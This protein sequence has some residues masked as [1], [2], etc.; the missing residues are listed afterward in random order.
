MKKLFLYLL[1]LISSATYG[2]QS[3]PN[4]FGQFQ[5]M[6]SPTT[7]TRVNGALYAFAGFVNGAFVDTLSANFSNISLSPGAQIRTG[8]RL[9][10]RNS[11]ATAWIE[12]TPVSGA[13]TVTSVGFTGGLISVANPTTT[14][15]FTVAGT[16]GGIPYFSSTSTWATSALLAANSLMIGGGAGVAPST[17]TTGTGVVTALG[18]NVGSAGAFV[19][20]GGALGTP[21]SGVLTNATGLPLTTGV[22]GTLPIANG[23]TGAATTSQNFAFIGPTSGSGAPSFR[24]L[25]SGDIPNNA[26]N[27][28]GSAATLTTSRNIYGGAFNGSADLTGI[29]PSTFGGTG[30]GFAKF[31]GAT[32]SEKTYTLPDASTTILTTNYTGALITGILKN[33][34]STGAL[35]IAIAADFPTLNQNTTGSAAT[36]TTSRNINGVAFNGSAD[37]TVTAAAGTLTGATLASGVTA[38][39]L[40]SFGTSP[41][42]V[43]PILGT[44]TSVT[45][46]NATGLPEGGLSLTDITTANTS[47][48]AHGFF[49]KLTANSVY[50]VNN[51]GA[52]VALTVGASGTVLTGNG[53]TSAP[54]WA[55][56]AGG[57]TASGNFG[58]IQLNRNTAFA[59][60]DS[61][62]YESATGLD[63]Y[64]TY[65]STKI[66][67]TAATIYTG[68]HLFDST[69]ASSN[70]QMYSPALSF[71]GKGWKT[72][73]TAESQTVNFKNYV[74]PVQGSTAPT[75][76]L[77]WTSSIN[78]A[79]PTTNMTLSNAGN[80][81]LASLTV[82]GNSYFGAVSDPSAKIQIAAGS[83]SANTAPLKFTSGSLN[84]TAVA[85]QVE[86]N[87]NH[88]ITSNAARLGA[89]GSLASFFTDVSNTGTGS[90]ETIYTYTMPANTM[91]TDGDRVEFEFYIS[92]PDNTAS[93]LGRVSFTNNVTANV[94]VT[95]GITTNHIIIRGVIQRYS[96]TT[97]RAAVSTSWSSNL[98]TATVVNNISDPGASFTG[99]IVIDFQVQ[100]T[101]AG[102]GGAGDAVGKGAW[103]NFIPHANN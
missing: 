45:L 9:W 97:C 65:T 90:Y 27:T 1:V 11:T 36:L 43:T 31:S 100:V 70:N 68:I 89:G 82:T 35:T 13:G 26:A 54:T 18:V 59:G 56:A 71:T 53:V 86:Y 44:P 23:G 91:N 57:G 20:N 38:S 74:V 67:A 17:T 5:Q 98:G 50:Y 69:V 60:T 41:T 7:W 63:L 33:T 52:L 95:G 75:G 58:N 39:S 24:L 16:S 40:T 46:T 10:F 103:V 3:Q 8:N 66:G 85:G 32:I 29:I 49:P 34:T 22:T 64:N 78:G 47:T 101:S 62:D 93:A 21:S 12:L 51:S 48:S 88:Y 102:T 76:N 81:N 25:V 87:G 28:T 14:P 37:I 61:L 77:L 92:C 30:N 99:S 73:A 72:T 42:L 84:T 4:T 6:G 2:Q 55:A 19:V 96:A 80:L 79:A 94:T 15:A 83:T